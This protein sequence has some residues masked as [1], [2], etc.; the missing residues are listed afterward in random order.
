MNEQ[1]V[2]YKSIIKQ[3]LAKSSDL[4]GTINFENSAPECP[5]LGKQYR[6][7][8][9]LYSYNRGSQTRGHNPT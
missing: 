8:K 4:L 1:V 6:T 9:D 7:I 2:N 3:N 5:V